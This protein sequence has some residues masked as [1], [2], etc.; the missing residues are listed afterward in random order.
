MKYQKAVLSQ[1]NRGTGQYSIV[2]ITALSYGGPS[3]YNSGTVKQT[4]TTFAQIGF[5]GVE[6]VKLVK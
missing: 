3:R 2:A 1:G 6:F 5:W 4:R